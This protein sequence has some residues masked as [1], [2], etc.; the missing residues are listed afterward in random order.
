[1]ADVAR[2][3]AGAAG[4][5]SDEKRQRLLELV[6]GRTAARPTDLAEDEV[7]VWPTLVVV[8]AL[9]AVIFTFLLLVASIAVNPPLVD[10]ANPTV[11][12]NPSKAPWYFLNLQELL[13]HMHPALAGVIVPTM[14]LVLI[15][16]IPFVDRSPLGVGILFTS[17]KGKKI[18]VF[19]AIFTTIVLIALIAFDS[20]IGVTRS[21]SGK[22]APVVYEQL[23]PVA[24]MVG[25]SVVLGVLVSKIYRPTRRELI[26][27]LFT[28]FVVSYF[29]LTIVGTFFRGYGMEIQLY[30]PWTNLHEGAH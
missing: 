25:F 6:R 10:I 28:G 8:E 19:S 24:V 15:A 27:A 20:E 12:P 11:T 17:D 1:M 26:I 5:I 29:V 16:A 2:R 13:L 9:S 7:M 21:L 23:I 18:T 4:G 30:W 3:P 14:A 22:V